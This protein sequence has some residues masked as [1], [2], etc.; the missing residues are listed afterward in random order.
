MPLFC[1]WC[2]VYKINKYTEKYDKEKHT[3][4]LL[5]QWNLIDAHFIQNEIFLSKKI[6]FSLS[7]HSPVEWTG[8]T[9]LAT[10]TFLFLPPWGMWSFQARD[11]TQAAVVTYATAAA[12]LD[13]YPAVLG[14]GLNL[15]PKPQRS[16]QSHC[17]TAGTLQH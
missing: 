1:L 8:I 16:H 11:Q 3:L 2:N 9:K 17:A 13:P 12:E 5:L 7:H 4:L 14:W 10:F 6:L 15:S